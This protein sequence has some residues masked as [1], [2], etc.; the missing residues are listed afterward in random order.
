MSP[1]SQMMSQR[2]IRRAS[3]FNMDT[4]SDYHDGSAAQRRYRKYPKCACNSV[5]DIFGKPSGKSVMVTVTGSHGRFDVRGLVRTRLR[6][7]VTLDDDLR[8]R[9]LVLGLLLCVLLLCLRFIMRSLPACL[10]IEISFDCQTAY[11]PIP[12]DKL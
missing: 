9:G 6:G 7:L 3:R 12:N 2:Q 8:L 11:S 4:D 5:V 1:N 10:E